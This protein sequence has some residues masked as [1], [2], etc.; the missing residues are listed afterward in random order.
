MKEIYVVGAAIIKNGQILCTK[1]ATDRIV[2]DLWEFPGGKIEQG[3]TPEEA[4]TRE[5]EEELGAEIVVGPKASTDTHE[6]SF[7][8]VHLSVYYAKFVKESFDLVAH[9]KMQWHYQQELSQLKW[10]PAD[11]S[12]MQAIQKQD[13]NQI[14]FR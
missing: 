7:G 3:E 5:L 13:L 1:R 12:A 4:L 8:N 9:S 11:V 10:A 6:Y 2:G 14:E